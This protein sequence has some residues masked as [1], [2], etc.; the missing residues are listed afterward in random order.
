M[1]PVAVA[2]FFQRGREVLRMLAFEL[3]HA[4][5]RISV[6][7]AVDAMATE[8]GVRER[9]TLLRIA[10]NR[11]L[12]GADRSAGNR[13]ADSYGDEYTRTHPRPKPLKRHRPLPNPR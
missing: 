1:R 8:A 13:P 10:L 7:V 5:V 6:L 2:I 11:R 4:V 9:L 12:L 3:G